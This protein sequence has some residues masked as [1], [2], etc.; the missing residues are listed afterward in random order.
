[1]PKSRIPRPRNGPPKSA[2]RRARERG[3][4]GAVLPA[5]LAASHNATARKA[6]HQA[7]EPELAPLG[8]PPAS[9]PPRVKHWWRE[10]AADMPQLS[11]RDRHGVLDYCRKMVEQES[12]RKEVERHGRFER[13]AVGV[14]KR[15][16]VVHGAMQPTAA[17]KALQDAGK[18]L[19]VMRRDFAALA[20]HRSRARTVPAPV[21][22]LAATQQQRAPV[23][24]LAALR[25]VK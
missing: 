24:K 14:D 10:T 8:E 21:E 18:R 2:L 17:Y 6:D 1:M 12:L 16:N 5:E 20:A 11:Q 19:H 7:P 25:P 9:A 22:P 13:P 3:G 23:S 4:R 15:G